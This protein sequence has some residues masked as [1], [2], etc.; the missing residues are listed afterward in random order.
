MRFTIR[1][2]KAFGKEVRRLAAGYL[3][4]AIASLEQQPDGPHEAVHA[5]RKQFKRLRGLYR[6][7]AEADKAF[8]EAENERIGGIARALA[9]LRDTT[10]RIEITRH[11]AV[12][13]G[14]AEEHMALIRICERLIARR[15]QEGNGTPLAEMIGAAIDGCRDARDAVKMFR[16]DGGAA[17]EIVAKGWE[18]TARK[19]QRAFA[20]ARATGDAENFHT[21]RKRTQDRWMH[22]GFLV[23]L[24]PAALR[25]SQVEAKR[26]VDLLGLNQ[27]IALL[28]TFADHHPDALGPSEDLSHLLSVMIAEGDRIRGDVLKLAADIFRDDP[29]GDARRVAALWRLAA[30]A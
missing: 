11:L 28:G 5:A 10:S 4:R 8:Q 12:A 18:R 1:P 30:K 2:D 9:G 19:A 16:P 13:A 27:D 26:L 24:W 17:A 15:D 25:S 29:A 23:D 7:V 3:D 22:C 14:T 20:D 6:L 21:L